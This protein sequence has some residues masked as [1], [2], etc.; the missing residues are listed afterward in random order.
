MIQPRCAV[1]VSLISLIGVGWALIRETQTF[2]ILVEATQY[3]TFDRTVD[4]SHTTYLNC[5]FN[6]GHLQRSQNSRIFRS[7]Q[8][9]E[10]LNSFNKS[11]EFP[12]Y[13]RPQIQ[14]S[15][16]TQDTTEYK[17][18][19]CFWRNYFGFIVYLMG[20]HQNSTFFTFIFQ[21]FSK[22]D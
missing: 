20:T 15:K 19:R 4:M 1:Q 10:I 14:T 9:A 8:N 2:R 22:W 16:N 7:P 5:T 18:K 12:S 13:N 17:N 3:N 6:H 11:P 21:I